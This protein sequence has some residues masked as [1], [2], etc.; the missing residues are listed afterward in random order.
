MRVNP[1]FMERGKARIGVAPSVSR[2]SKLQSD[3]TVLLVDLSLRFCVSNRFRCRL[4][5]HLRT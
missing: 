4:T 5:M 1:G 2:S 3:T